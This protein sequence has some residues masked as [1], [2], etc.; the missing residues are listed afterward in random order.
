MFMAPLFV[1]AKNQKQANCSSID[2]WINCV[3]PHDG[4]LF[5]NKKIIELLIHMKHDE[6]Q[7]N[8]PE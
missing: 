6:P 1:V 4:M 7:N 3:Y 8:Y 2:E 5:C